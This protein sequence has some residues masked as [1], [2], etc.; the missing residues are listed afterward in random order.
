MSIAV[1][2]EGPTITRIALSTTVDVDLPAE[3]IDE[4][5]Q[6][7]KANCPVS[8]ALTGVGDVSLTVTKA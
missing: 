4:L 2:D 1:T 5:A 7:A 6:D 3:K 8:K